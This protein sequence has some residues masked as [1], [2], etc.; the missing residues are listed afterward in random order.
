DIRALAQLQSRE[1]APAPSPLFERV[2]QTFVFWRQSDDMFGPLSPDRAQSFRG[3]KGFERCGGVDHLNHGVWGA[4]I[5]GEAEKRFGER[6]L[7]LQR[8]ALV[9]PR[10][11]FTQATLK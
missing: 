1:V 5:G 8:G 3:R 11:H 2:S 10:R 4:N 7:R 9:R 6:F